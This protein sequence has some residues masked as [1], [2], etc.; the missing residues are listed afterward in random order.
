MLVYL[1]DDDDIYQFT[2][3]KMLEATGLRVLVHSFANGLE[4]LRL[5]AAGEGSKPDIIF[6]DINMP[7]M[8]GWDFLEACRSMLPMLGKQVP[9]YIVSSS[10]DAADMEKAGK[11]ALVK[12]YM[13]KPVKPAMFHHVLCNL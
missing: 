1:I 7:V 13:V 9:I 5:S 10:A 3:R 2:A 11:S 12:G 8:N 6:L 4:G